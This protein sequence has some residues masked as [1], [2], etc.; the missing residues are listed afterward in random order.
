MI[1]ETGRPSCGQEMGE[2][3]PCA[4]SHAPRGSKSRRSASWASPV[5]MAFG[6]S[7]LDAI[8]GAIRTAER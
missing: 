4:G 2:A 5:A 6:I 7:G 1:S 3:V 8:R